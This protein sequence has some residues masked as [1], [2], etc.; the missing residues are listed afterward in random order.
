[1][2]RRRAAKELKKSTMASPRQVSGIGGA[3]E[4]LHRC[5]CML[6][7]LLLHGLRSLLLLLRRE[8]D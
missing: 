1:M 5:C 8:K 2:G 7:L 6:L 4:V 3:R